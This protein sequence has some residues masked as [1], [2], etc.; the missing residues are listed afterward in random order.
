MCKVTCFVEGM[1]IGVAA[2]VGVAI[3]GKIMIDNS[4]KLTKGKNKL[5]KAVTEFVDG[6]Q[7]MIG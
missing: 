5:E 4:K 3:A 6:V 7:T 2:G 1:L